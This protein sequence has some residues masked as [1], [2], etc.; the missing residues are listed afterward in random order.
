M[1]VLALLLCPLAL[2]A[3]SDRG[4]LTGSV[5]DAGRAAMPGAAIVATHMESWTTFRGSSGESGEFNIP[6]LPVG[7]YKVVLELAGFKSAVRSNVRVEAGASARLDVKLEVGEVRQTVEVRESSA[8]LQIDNA[9]IQNTM[10]DRMI[11]ALPT[12]MSD[13]RRSPF[14]L[15]AITAQV[16]GGDQDFRIG[17]GQ[18]GAFGV[19]L[20]GAS[21][22][23]NRAGS[24]L[25]A[26]VNAPS[27]DAI[28]EFAVETNGFK[29][30][31]GRAGGIRQIRR[32]GCSSL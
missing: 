24:T 20:D 19:Q 22:G 13:N 8:Q 17:G 21:A 4:L 9:K 6:S 29:A 25:W 30:E 18:A 16:N 1:K 31:F 26:A 10:S 11:G 5:M 2:L 27:L 28:T 15:A 7:A 32:G 14:D 3:Q 12:V 23:T